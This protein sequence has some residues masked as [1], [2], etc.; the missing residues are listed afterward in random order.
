MKE[1]HVYECKITATVEIYVPLEHREDGRMMTD[2][3]ML[4]D[5]NESAANHMENDYYIDYVGATSR[6]MT[7]KD[8]DG[9][10]YDILR[11]EGVEPLSYYDTE[12]SDIRPEKHP[13]HPVRIFHVR[14]TSTLFYCPEMGYDW[15]FWRHLPK[16]WVV[17]GS[18]NVEMVGEHDWIY[19]D[20]W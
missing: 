16:R 1:Y 9:Y 18:M 6:Y 17:R 2:Q 14:V 15:R 5:L 10:E 7:C 13:A 19:P 11:V 3:E 12:L 8:P 4:E 20:L